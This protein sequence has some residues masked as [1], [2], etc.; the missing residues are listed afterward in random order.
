MSAEMRDFAAAFNHG[1]DRGVGIYEKDQQQA[2]EREKNKLLRDQ[3]EATA[4]NADR[5]TDIYA[6]SVKSA[7]ETNRI[8]A[9]AALNKAAGKGG[10]GGGGSASPGSDIV[11]QGLANAGIIVPKPPATQPINVTVAAPDR[12]DEGGGVPMPSMPSDGY[13]KGGMV[14]KYADGGMTV[15]E[16]LSYGPKAS[17]DAGQAPA[18]A[19]GATGSSFSSAYEKSAAAYEK[20]QAADKEKA[21]AARTAASNVRPTGPVGTGAGGSY[22]TSDVR[23][24]GVLDTTSAGI[25]GTDYRRGGRVRRFAGGGMA[26]LS[27]PKAAV[28]KMADTPA[29]KNPDGST[30]TKDQQDD[31]PIARTSRAVSSGGGDWSSVGGSADGATGSG[32]D[33]AGGVSGSGGV[34]GSASDDA[35]GS[36]AAG[37]GGDDG[38][39]YRRGGRV[40]RFAG[41][42][43]VGSQH[44]EEADQAMQLTPPER[45]LYERHL[46]NL[47]GT[48]GKDNP[49]GS[50]STIYNM[51]ME[52]NGRTYVVPTIYNGQA[53]RPDDAARMAAQ[54][55]MDT[56]PSYPT[57]KQADARYEQMHGYMERDTQDR[58]QRQQDEQ[59]SGTGATY[60]RGGRVRR[61]RA[62]GAVTPPDRAP[63]EEDYY[64]DEPEFP[65]DERFMPPSTR[66]DSGRHYDNPNITQEPE[67]TFIRRPQNVEPPKTRTPENYP[68]MRGGGRVRRFQSGGRVMEAAIDTGTSG[69]G[70][71]YGHRAAPPSRRY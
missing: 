63:R 38:G 42:G 48:G 16:A 52:H 15:S 64:T 65:D 8:R 5:R 22:S 47:S 7:S 43:V 70:S 35:G 41:G 56:F 39:T 46:G 55:G 3:H 1:L 51:T 62:G 9:Q 25:G 40:R 14:K 60:R 45:A 36:A 17:K 34:G 27:D 67:D 11:D 53:L 24:G 37:V 44:A 58:S 71:G 49:D 33:S 69:P 13:K 68:M 23:P 20:K 28:L 26:D 59:M 66:N 10:G 21:D 50:R 4:R 18:T 57:Q 2:I 54:Q 6:D 30:K 31:G 19:A 12:V 61:Y 29:D 32:G